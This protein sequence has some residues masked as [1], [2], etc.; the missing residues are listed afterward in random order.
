MESPTPSSG[1]YRGKQI[2]AVLPLIVKEPVCPI[3]HPDLEVGAGGQAGSAHDACTTQGVN[4]DGGRG[5]ASS[6]MSLAQHAAPQPTWGTAICHA[7]PHLPCSPETA[8][9]A[10]TVR[11]M[12]LSTLGVASPSCPPCGKEVGEVHQPPGAGRCVPGSRQRSTSHRVSSG[13]CIPAH[14]HPPCCHQRQI[15]QHTAHRTDVAE[16]HDWR[17]QC[18][19][20]NA[21]HL[22]SF[23]QPDEIDH[24]E[25]FDH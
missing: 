14:G 15:K 23:L 7:K 2:C 25:P 24:S 4:N 16:Q 12:A 17:H 8:V 21:A 22:E 3:L 6:N 20:H 9:V 11:K 10:S 13:R 19:A 5:S 18:A 1:T